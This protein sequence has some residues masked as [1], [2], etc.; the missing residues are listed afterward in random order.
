[1][2][3]TGLSK[4]PPSGDH[5]PAPKPKRY[6]WR[7][8]LGSVMIVTAV[9]TATAAS[10]LL[11][12]GSIADALSHNDKLKNKVERVLAKTEGGEPQNI[13]ILGSDKR[14]SEPEDTG[15]SQSFA[16]GLRSRERD[17][18]GRGG[19]DLPP[20]GGSTSGKGNNHG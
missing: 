13:L 19:V 15:R 1:M 4:P 16:L 17:S 8:T 11:Y 7:F 2:A 12:I 9:A 18:P 14:A 3:E 20:R 10:I 6:W 5:E